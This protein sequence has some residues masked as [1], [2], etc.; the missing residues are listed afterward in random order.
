[1]NTLDS[2]PGNEIRLLSWN[3]STDSHI[4]EACAWIAQQHPDAVLW[5]GLHPDDLL[6]VQK[7][8]HMHG[9]PAIPLPGSPHSNAIFVHDDGLFAVE[10]EYEHGWAP[11][12][13]PAN[14]AVRLR[15]AGGELSERVLSLVSKHDCSWS[16][17]VRS[18]E[19]DWYTTFAAPGYLLIGMGDWNG[20]PTEARLIDW[21]NVKDKAFMVN[22]TYIAEDGTRRTDDR[23]D[24]IL[25]A[26]GFIDAARHVAHELGQHSAQRATAGYGQAGTRQAGPQRIDRTVLSVE[27]GASIKAYTVGDP[28]PDTDQHLE[29]LSGHRPQQL[30]LYLDRL[31]NTMQLPPPHAAP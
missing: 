14:I 25:T 12:H 28:D 11:W 22:R 16:A 5:Q 26:A 9:Y 19:A 6:R 23:A 8:L 31:Q 17:T 24:R 10:D 2:H 30:V 27:L 1:M 3:V 13:A 21:R 18:I 7:L 29:T 4:V 15:G 20:M